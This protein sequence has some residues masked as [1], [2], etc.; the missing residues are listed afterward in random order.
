MSTP[1]QHAPKQGLRVAI[2]V[3]TATRKQGHRIALYLRTATQGC[4]KY[5][6]PIKKQER[7]LRQLVR[8]RN[9]WN[10]LGEIVDVFADEGKS[11][12][13]TDRPEL[14]RLLSSIRDR[15]I[16]VVLVTDLS[17]LSRSPSG[18]IEIFEALNEGGC[19]LGTLG[20]STLPVATMLKS[21]RRMEVF[22]A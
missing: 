20:A 18:L 1:N 9:R 5:G 2:Y 3:R 13:N 10:T 21:Y 22:H 4:Q 19:E 17:R 15:K 6:N 12:L 11:G 7:N 14:R 16:T 8:K